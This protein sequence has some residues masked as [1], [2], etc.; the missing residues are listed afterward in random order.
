MTT[1]EE[2]KRVVLRIRDEIEQQGNLDAIEEIFADD[3]V[4]HT[5]MGE[6]SG[7]EAVK[8]MYESDR[9]AFSDATETVHDLIAEGDVVAARMTEGGTHAGEFI[10]IEPT[11]R[12]YEIQTM[13]F[14]HLEDGKVT[15][16]WIQPDTLGFM[17][18]LGVDLEDLSEAVPA[19]DD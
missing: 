16:W 17:R 8:E 11:G 5:P 19:A 14:L 4:V 1:A 15:E 10:G 6:F 12:E 18:Q 13:A 9:V 3:V 7:H 2:N